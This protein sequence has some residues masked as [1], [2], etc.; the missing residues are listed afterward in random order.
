MV[1]GSNKYKTF[2]MHESLVNRLI[3]LIRVSLHE[4]KHDEQASFELIHQVVIIFASFSL[5]RLDNI[6]RLIKTHSLHQLLLNVIK[7]NVSS[8]QLNV[9]IIE[10]CLR[11]ISNLYATCQLVPSLIYL[12]DKQLYACLNDSHHQLTCLHLLLKV[13]S[14]SAV[15]KQTVIQIVS[16]S[17]MFIAT[18]LSASSRKQLNLK[19]DRLLKWDEK[20]RR[21]RAVLVSSDCIGKFAYLL[22]SAAGQVQLN[23][24]KFYASVC[25]ENVEALNLV[26]TTSC[27]DLSLLELISAYLSRE[28]SAELQLYAAKCLT[29]LCRSLLILN[30]YKRISQDNNRTRR[31]KRLSRRD[32][33]FKRLLLAEET[34]DSC[35]ESDHIENDE[36]YDDESEVSDTEPALVTRPNEEEEEE[37]SKNLRTLASEAVELKLDN[38]YKLVDS[39]S[40]LIR[41]KT[42]PT[43]IRLCCTYSINYR[44]CN[45]N[46]V[47]GGRLAETTN[48]FNGS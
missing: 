45:Q 17:S 4:A 28:N 47:N 20:I 37:A 6:V 48:Y 46:G 39:S 34:A 35:D 5:G 40:Y 18:M 8:E 1:I 29:N 23:A 9:R 12:L 13:Y 41:A 27:Y 22:T 33:K 19:T 32:Y 16:I 14:M 7:V 10:S 21:N 24:L 38:L 26:L 15:T 31:L 36:L 3:E 11:C 30:N 43:L 44:N 42:L 2:F 25:F